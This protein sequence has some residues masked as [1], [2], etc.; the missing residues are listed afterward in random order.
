MKVIWSPLAIEKLKD[1]TAYIS[2]DNP[3]AAHQL[4]E[5]LFDLADNITA[6]PEKGRKVPELA[7]NRY[8]ELIYGNYRLIYKITNDIHI[9]TIRN[10]RQLL[11]GNDI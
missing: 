8:R 11:S 6:H 2:Q 7:D 5:S 1:I 9:L 4:A 3:Q 10:C